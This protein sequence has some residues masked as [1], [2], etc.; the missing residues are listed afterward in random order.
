MNI[1]AVFSGG[2]VKAFGLIGALQS[3]EDNGFNIVRSAGT[4]A[5]AILSSLIAAN[6]SSKE[7]KQ[8]FT[9]LP[10][11]QF[12]DP[13]KMTNILPVSKWYFLYFKMGFYK[14]NKLEKWLEDVLAKKNVRTFGD[15][16]DGSLKMIVTDLTLKQLV[17]LPDD[18][19]D[20]YGINPKD[21]SVAKA[22]RIS[23][24]FPLAFMPKKIFNNKLN[25][26]S[27]LV[28][29]GVVS[30]FP[31]WIFEKDHERKIRPVLGVKL[32]G[33]AEETI[34]K[35]SADLLQALLATM[36]QSHD[37][38]FIHKYIK[39][40]VFIP[41]HDVDTLNVNL[42]EEKKLEMI[43]R[44]KKLTDLFLQNWPK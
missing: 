17:I 33:S 43:N 39:D 27:I 20:L 38:R 24:G 1:D 29:G 21:F 23:A 13:P 15:L 42:S 36:K 22:V 12:L 34:I 5:G 31:L 16:P 18:L 2:G 44:G 8:M 14:G 6:Y 28:D 35:N 26:E 10:I 4:S 25:N 32:A 9:T 11:E 7:I 30:N 3:I 37:E 19:D 41:I 40:V